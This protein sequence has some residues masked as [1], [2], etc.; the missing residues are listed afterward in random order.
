[1]RPKS[2]NVVS[3]IVAA[4]EKEEEEMVVLVIDM[5]ALGTVDWTMSCKY[6]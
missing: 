3:E 5:D 6:L 2:S 4:K 1:M